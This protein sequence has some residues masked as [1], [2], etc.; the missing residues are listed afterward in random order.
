MR[1]APVAIC[2]LALCLPT[3]AWANDN[4]TVVLHARTPSGTGTCTAAGLPN[5]VGIRPTTQVAAN[6][7]FRLYIFIRNH[8]ALGAMQTGFQWPADWVATPTGEPPF[9]FSCRGDTP[10]HTPVNPGGPIHGTLALAFE[11][12]T[13]PA[14]CAIGRIDF[15]AGAGGCL[16][17]INPIQG[18]GRVE[19]LD[20][21]N[22]STTLDATTP[23]GQSRL[24]S[25]CV[26]VPGR[27]ACDAITT[28]VEPATWGSVKATYR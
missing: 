21:Q 28:A 18:T 19:V 7:E 16:E 20:C 9:F 10:A 4:F 14:L 2:L 15:F 22:N 26:G 17:Q 5:C 8:T 27:D 1:Y 13:S 23:H 3:V 24:G 25:I 11:C 12:F 6:T